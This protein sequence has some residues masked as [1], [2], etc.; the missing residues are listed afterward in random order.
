MIR[1]LVLILA[2][3]GPGVA[4]A[5]SP[6][7]KPGSNPPSPTTEPATTATRACVVISNPFEFCGGASDFMQTDQQLNADVAAFFRTRAGFV[8]AIVVDPRADLRGAT[9]PDLQAAVLTNLARG[10]GSRPEEITVVEQNALVID[11]RPRPTLI[12]FGQIDGV[13][14]VYSNTFIVLDEIVG[15][16]IT[17]EP[18]VDTFTEEHRLRHA[19]FLD[20]IEGT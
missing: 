5:Q 17:I 6:A 13:D 1:V 9:L 7:P 10:T 11:G 4:I 20:L 19:E 8:A 2:L 16:F 3:F 12:Y 18:N 15:Q 14:Y